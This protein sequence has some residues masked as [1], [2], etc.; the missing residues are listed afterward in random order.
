MFFRAQKAELKLNLAV[1]SEAVKC[2]KQDIQ[3]SLMTLYLIKKM[4]DN[5][6]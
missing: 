6:T 4:C 5:I 3:Q 2:H 1:Q